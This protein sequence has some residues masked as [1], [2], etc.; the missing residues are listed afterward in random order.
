MSRRIRVA[1]VFSRLNIGGPSIHVV[2]LTRGLDPGRFE[3]TLLVGSEDR[4][5]GNMNDFAS[6]H[7]VVPVR[8]GS[9]GRRISPLRDVRATWELYRFLRS[10]RPDIVHTHTAKAGF[11]GRLAARAARVPVVVHT[12][13]GHVFEGYFGP[14]TTR[15]FVLIERRLAAMSDAIVAVS[16][17]VKEA[18]VSRA[19]APEGKIRVVPLGLE[20]GPFAAVSGPAGTYRREL[21]LAGND[22]LV[23]IVG[24]LV[25]VKDHAT[26]LDAASKIARGRSDVHFA[27]VGDGEL[28][29]P[30]EA[31]ASQL[32]LNRIVH[33]SGWRR[34]LPQIY[35]DL[36]VVVLCSRNEGT[37]VSIIE[38]SASG[39]P[40]VVTA[41]GGVKDIVDDG[42]TGLLLPPG[43][44]DLLAASILRILDDGSLASR[45]GK[46]AR[47]A[48]LGRHHV[49][50]LVSDI[51][52]LYL[53]LLGTKG[54]KL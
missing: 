23:G 46:N 9:L 18:L 27:I 42:V 38:A 52:N 7:G 48:V 33:F 31:R 53:E 2:L 15:A 30:L 4:R 1:R 13:H 22:R 24:R 21:G 25:P 19:V 40:S 37:P 6:A 26:F 45:L 54:I 8:L 41:V 50:R 11:T 17:G 5:E 47:E 35:A 39:R 32:G 28:R 3:T 12:F 29:A 16:P 36:D 10:W 34:D 49:G 20:L 44:S 43:D 51:E 14:A